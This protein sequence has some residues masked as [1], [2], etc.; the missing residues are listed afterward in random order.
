MR[1]FEDGLVGILAA[2]AVLAQA[3]SVAAQQAAGG[4]PEAD[5]SDVESID[6][7]VKATYDVISGGIGEQ[8]NWDRFRSLFI[9]EAK[10]VSSGPAEGGGFGYLVW[11][12]DDFVSRVDSSFMANGFFEVELTRKVERFGQIAHLFSTYGSRRLP[13]DPAPYQRGINSFQL[14]WD[15]DRWWIINIFFTGERADKPIPETY[16]P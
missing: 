14:M 13:D 4:W 8:R 9:P 11:S 1:R 5:P 2:V 3:P 16:L 10:I 6:A 12:I 7:I 15:G